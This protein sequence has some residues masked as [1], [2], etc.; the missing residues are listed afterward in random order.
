MCVVSSHLVAKLGNVSVVHKINIIDGATKTAFLLP[1][2]DKLGQL[3]GEVQRVHCW[4][5]TMHRV[6]R[7]VVGSIVGDEMSRY[8][9]AQMEHHLK[10]CDGHKNFLLLTF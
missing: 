1:A 5:A 4:P 9:M 3:G 8:G 6:F 2:R 10:T 7:C